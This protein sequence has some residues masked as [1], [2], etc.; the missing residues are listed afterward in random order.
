MKATTVVVAL[1]AAAADAKRVC[2]R[3]SAAPGA[4]STG[5][6]LRAIN[7]I[8]A[9]GEAF[10]SSWLGVAHSAVTTVVTETATATATTTATET[11]TETVTNLL[12]ETST[13][14]VAV[15]TGTTTVTQGATTVFMKRAVPSVPSVDEHADILSG[16]RSVSSRI[17]SACSCFLKDSTTAAVLVSQ[18]TTA[19]TT[20]TETS[21]KTE[22]TTEVTATTTVIPETVTTALLAATTVP[23][24]VTIPAQPI[25]VPGLESYVTTGNIAPWEIKTPAGGKIEIINGV[26]ACYVEG[27]V[28]T[29][30][31]GQ[32]VIRPYPPPGGY[33]GIVQ[34]FQAR[35][36]T[37]YNFSFLVRCL[38]Y[39]SNSGIDVRYAGTI[40]GGYRCN[41][42][43]FVKVSGILFTTDATGRGLIDIRFVGTADTPYLYFYADNFMATVV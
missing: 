8:P 33:V 9:L 39:D 17:S 32:V 26:N 37:K 15:T 16:C 24:V 4:C 5:K 3:P 43:S 35:P 11:A 23:A 2:T 38:N 20:V 1:L 18:T 25:L 21:L 31:G 29:C 40:V 6:C 27:G 28:T 13:T 42:G 34:E 22:T 14:V 7:S 41:G 30:G 10:C 36:S 19:T 12:T